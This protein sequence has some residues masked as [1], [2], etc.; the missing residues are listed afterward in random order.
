MICDDCGGAT[1]SVIGPR[2]TACLAR[3]NARPISERT[4]ILRTP[5]AWF[6]IDDPA[7]WHALVGKGAIRCACGVTS[8]HPDGWQYL[9]ATPGRPLCL[10]GAAAAQAAAARNA[11]LPDLLRASDVRSRSMQSL[12][13]RK[14][15]K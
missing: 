12:G 4:A 6:V 7:I 2:C 11:G 14:A 15:K 5:I 3:F 8:L 10:E 1:G 9:Q 13:R